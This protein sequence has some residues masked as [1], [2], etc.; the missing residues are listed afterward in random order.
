MFGTLEPSN[1]CCERS[2]EKEKKTM[3]CCSPSMTRFYTFLKQ[4]TRPLSEISH[5]GRISVEEVHAQSS[6][7]LGLARR[8]S[9]AVE[10]ALRLADVC[11]GGGGAAVAYPV[12]L[13][14]TPALASVLDAGVLVHPAGLEAL[15]LRHVGKIDDLLGEEAA[16]GRLRHAAVVAEVGVARVERRDD[17][18][19]GGG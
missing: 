17:R 16:R 3:C 1:R 19:A 18:G 7:A 6:T 4:Q 5:L 9:W 15:L 2:Q 11:S 14:T 12:D 13:V 8:V 10:G